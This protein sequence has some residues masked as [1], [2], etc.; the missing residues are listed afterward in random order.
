[1][2]VPE[3]VR[4]KEFV[5]RARRDMPLS[6]FQ[7]RIQKEFPQAN[8]IGNSKE[9]DDAKKESK[10][11][12]YCQIHKISPKPTIHPKERFFKGHDV[13][14]A[15]VAYYEE[16]DVRTFEFTRPKWKGPKTENE[17]E[18]LWTEIVVVQTAVCLPSQQNRVLIVSKEAVEKAPI[19]TAVE[20]MEDK[21]KE[22]QTIIGDHSRSRDLNI[23]PL[24]MALNGVIDAAVMG[25]T[26]KYRDAFFTPAFRQANPELVPELER[27]ERLIAT[28]IE[29]LK[30]GVSVHRS[31]CPESLMPMQ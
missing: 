11:E 19:V 18:N 23:N 14:K 9:I 30:M 16:N 6:L 15:L 1:M 10:R 29:I 31:K 13:P 21:N 2:D 4:N 12:T 26:D 25:G 17:F 27:L 22:L 5:Y 3:S 20:T 24:T 7:D 28:Q 8:M